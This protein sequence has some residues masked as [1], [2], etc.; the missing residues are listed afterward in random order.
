MADAPAAG[1][2]EGIKT[3]SKATGVQ[4]TLHVEWDPKT[5]TLVVRACA[6]G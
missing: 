4:R 2:E 6:E 3:V 1:E 5:G